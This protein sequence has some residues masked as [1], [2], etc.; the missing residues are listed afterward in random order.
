[1]DRRKKWL[2]SLRSI[3]LNAMPI[4]GEWIE[5]TCPNCGSVLAKYHSYLRY[6]REGPIKVQG[7]TEVIAFASV[8]GQ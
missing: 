1:M 6:K 7:G 4:Q 3:G 2:K 8:P 5:H